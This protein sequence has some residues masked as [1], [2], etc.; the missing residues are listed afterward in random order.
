[1][2]FKGLSES[3]KDRPDLI[4]FSFI[5][6]DLIRVGKNFMYGRGKPKIVFDGD[7]ASVQ[8][9]VNAGLRH[10]TYADA[11]SNFSLLY[12]YLR[13][14]ILPNSEYYAPCLYQGYY[15]KAYGY[16]YE[17]MGMLA[18]EQSVEVVFVKLPN[19]FEFRGVEKLI[20]IAEEVFAAGTAPRVSYYDIDECVGRKID[21]NNPHVDE[22]FYF[23]PTT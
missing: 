2:L 5:P 20:P 22:M 8:P 17:E 7:E 16:I 11:L 4:L 23:H 19:S 18:D 15:R 12:W 13:Y 1:M 21:L 6:H 10:G 14:D 9:A 3:H